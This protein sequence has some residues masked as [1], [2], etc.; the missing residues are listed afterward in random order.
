M[1]EREA[2]RGGGVLIQKKQNSSQQRSGKP[3]IWGRYK[4]GGFLDRLA[5]EYLRRGEGEKEYRGSKSITKRPP[6]KEREGGGGRSR[7]FDRK[8]GREFGGKEKRGEK[9]L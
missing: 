1:G 9:T 5:K 7:D 6:A 4:S 3:S 2:E 8:K